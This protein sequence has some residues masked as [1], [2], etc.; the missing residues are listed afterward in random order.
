MFVSTATKSPSKDLMEER[1]DA[2]SAACEVKVVPSVWTF[3]V[4]PGRCRVTNM[5]DAWQQ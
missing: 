5:K 1:F 3:D 4:L 2:L